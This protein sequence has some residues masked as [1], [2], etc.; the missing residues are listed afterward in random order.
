MF[1][2]S[3]A[4]VITEGITLHVGVQG[5]NP[6]TLITNHFGPHSWLPQIIYQKTA[7]YSLKQFREI[8]SVARC[9]RLKPS[10][11]LPLH[12]PWQHLHQPTLI[13]RIRPTRHSWD[14]PRLAAQYRRDVT[15][16]LNTDLI[17]VTFATVRRQETC[18][19]VRDHNTQIYELMKVAPFFSEEKGTKYSAFV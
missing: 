11:K 10:P 12:R 9:S 14:L 3:S 17:T 15:R 5:W 16:V 4:R 18:Q 8:S 1:H 6:D 7:A 19:Y 2:S 13:R